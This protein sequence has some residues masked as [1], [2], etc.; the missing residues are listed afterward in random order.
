MIIGVDYK[1]I[2]DEKGATALKTGIDMIATEIELLLNFKKY[3]LFF[4]N[5]MGLDLEKYLGLTN[6]LATFNLIKSDI[7]DL[8]RKYRRVKLKTIEITFNKENNEVLINVTVSMS[9]T[10]FNNITI[11]FKVQN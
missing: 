7:Q 4:G 5:N 9:G 8:F 11:P 10:N 6:R 2:Y 1:Q 3:S